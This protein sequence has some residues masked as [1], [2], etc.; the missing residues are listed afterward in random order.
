VATRLHPNDA[1]PWWLLTAAEYGLGNREAS[2]SALARTLAVVRKPLPREVVDTLLERYPSADELAARMPEALVPWTLVMESIIPAA[3]SY[4]AILAATRTQVDRQEP[5]V[6]RLQVRIALETQNPAL[7]RYHASLLRQLAPDD[8]VSHL[9]LVRALRAFAV[10]R[11]REIQA[12]IEQALERPLGD[13]AE[14]GLLEEE[15]VES[16]LR[17]GT[18]AARERARELLPR[19]LTRPGD[20]A[21]LQRRNALREALQGS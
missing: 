7:A 8:A 15:L 3:P 17:E 16:L 9:L 1:D 20:R 4:A 18:P 10:P 21:S 12:A 13:A 6:L 19:L 11:E 2:A 5:E 14:V